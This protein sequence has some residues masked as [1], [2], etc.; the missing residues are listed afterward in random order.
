MSYLS[1]PFADPAQNWDEDD[2]YEYDDTE[3]AVVDLDEGRLTKVN[4]P[5]YIGIVSGAEYRLDNAEGVSMY[6]LVVAINN[7]AAFFEVSDGDLECLA[8]QIDGL[9]KR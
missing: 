7:Q 1:D 8:R 2:G 6:A 5:D 9:L 3:P 4:R